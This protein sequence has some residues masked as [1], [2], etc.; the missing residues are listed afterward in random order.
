MDGVVYAYIYM[1][2][3]CMWRSM[4][5][6]HKVILFV[7][8]SHQSAPA[9]TITVGHQTPTP[10]GKQYISCQEV[11]QRSNCKMAKKGKGQGCFYL[12]LRRIRIPSPGCPSVLGLSA[13]QYASM[14]L[15]LFSDRSDN[16]PSENPKRSELEGDK[17]ALKRSNGN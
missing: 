12:S 17:G 9:P 10:R 3:I 7:K 8:G 2:Y 1:Y 6:G 13:L 15:F 14:L 4:V 5:E 11:K 16:S